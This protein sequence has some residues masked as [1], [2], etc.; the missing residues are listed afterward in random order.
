MIPWL[1]VF[2]GGGLGSMMR[3]AFSKYFTPFIFGNFYLPLAT[4]LANIVSCFI[5][6]LLLGKYL[7][8]GMTA[9]YKLLLATGFCGGFSTFSTLSLEMMLMI[10]KGNFGI[11]ILYIALTTITGLG[12]LYLGYKV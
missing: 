8:D 10:E 3:F 6:G 12:F 1:L 2:I 4:L 7:S 5:L 11:A 9:N